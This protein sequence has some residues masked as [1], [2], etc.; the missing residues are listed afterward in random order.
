MRHAKSLLPPVKQDALYK[1]IER[2]PRRF[3]PL[4]VPKA[5]QAAL[6]FKSKPKDDAPSRLPAKK[7][8]GP[9]VKQGGGG[10]GPRPAPPRVPVVLEPQEKKEAAMMHRLHTM[11]KDKEQKR[12]AKVG[13]QRAAQAKKRAKEDAEKEAASAKVRKKRYV[14]MGMEEKRQAKRAKTGGGGGDD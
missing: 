3:N 2:K 1:P 6:P 5:L 9:T 4:I 7:A 13:E 8:K 12:K 11:Y 10:G 14:R